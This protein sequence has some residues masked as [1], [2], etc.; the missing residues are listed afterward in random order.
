MTNQTSARLGDAE[1][2]DYL[3]LIEAAKTSCDGAMEY[4]RAY[5]VSRT[6]GPAL[7]EEVLRLR[8][9][10]VVADQ[11]AAA[12]RTWVDDELAHGLWVPGRVLNTLAAYEEQE[13]RS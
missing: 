7:A 11:M 3:S 9:R 5:R 6:I 12:V 10:V 13:A 4:V 1:I 2:E 8:A